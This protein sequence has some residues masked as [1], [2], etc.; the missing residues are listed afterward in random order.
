M[1]WGVL[2][3]WAF[4]L[5]LMAAYQI[6]GLMAERKYATER[7]ELE[8][9]MQ[10]IQVALWRAQGATRQVDSVLAMLGTIK[11]PV[12]QSGINP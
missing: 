3:A 5:L 10:T 11:H 2:T 9:T 1:L 6:G 12:S 7:L 8:R 4:V